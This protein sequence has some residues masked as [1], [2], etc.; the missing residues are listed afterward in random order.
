MGL[1]H[2]VRAR[3]GE[4]YTDRNGAEKES[5]VTIGRLI[6]SAKGN[7]MI[8]IDAIPLAWFAAGKPVTLFLQNKDR[9]ERPAATEAPP[10]TRR[11]AAATAPP[12]DIDDD[13]PF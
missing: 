8:I 6:E 7:K 10:Q 13:L 4:T 11:A 9:D 2:Y 5:Y 1:T 12:D 3:T